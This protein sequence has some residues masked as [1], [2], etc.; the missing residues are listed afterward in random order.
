MLITEDVAKIQWI[1][2]DK[3]IANGLTKRSA[4]TYDLLRTVQE[5]HLA[6]VVK[7]TWQS[8]EHFKIFAT[9][10]LYTELKKNHFSCYVICYVLSG[11]CEN[12]FFS[13]T[14]DLKK[15]LKKEHYNQC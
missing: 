2:G 3:V 13:T 11:H 15:C 9:L 5:G 1:P 12:L 7:T 6:V 14:H 4:Q 8:Y 10:V